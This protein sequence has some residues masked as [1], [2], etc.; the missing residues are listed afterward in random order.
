[1][2]KYHSI[3]LSFSLDLF[4]QPIAIESGVTEKFNF[5]PVPVNVRKTN[6]IIVKAKNLSEK[7]FKIIFNYGK[8][9]TKNGG[10]VVQVP[11]EESYNDFII[12]VGNQYKWFSEQCKKIMVH[13]YYALL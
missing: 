3:L 4:Y 12:R 11:Q 10:F 2:K 13:T 7:A 9:G 6:Y 1:M 5:E 8:G